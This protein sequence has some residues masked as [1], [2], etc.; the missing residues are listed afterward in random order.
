MGE[1]K[2]H[3][4]KPRGN[5]GAPISSCCC[6]CWEEEEEAAADE[7]LP[8]CLLL[9]SGVSFFCSFF[10]SVAPV[11]VVVVVAAGVEEEVG[12]RL[13]LGGEAET[14]RGREE[15]EEGGGEAGVMVMT[16]G[17]PVGGGA[18]LVSLLVPGLLPMIFCCI[19]YICVYVGGC[20]VCG[21]GGWRGEGG[22]E[23]EEVALAEG[24]KKFV[25]KHAAWPRLLA[26]S[27]ALPLPV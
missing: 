18:S 5:K 21:R 13:G 25:C 26:L 6:C 20:C 23:G 11:I 24:K 17:P 10:S 8:C 15:E 2:I 22:R 3:G 7:G 14:E 12:F 4:A 19:L 1:G 16:L 27:L 9:A